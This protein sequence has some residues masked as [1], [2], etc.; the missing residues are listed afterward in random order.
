MHP[1]DHL[2]AAG[3]ALVPL[4][5][6]G[7]SRPAL[8][9]F[10][11]TSVLLNVDHY[12]AYTWKTG[13]LSLWRAYQFH[14]KT[15]PRTHWGVQLGAP[16]LVMDRRRP[17]HALAPIAAVIVAARWWPVLLPAALGAGFHRLQDFLWGC[18]RVPVERSP[19]DE[20]A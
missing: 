12:V 4:A 18:A 16:A 20:N 17:L 6:R 19:A 13:D 1:R 14:Q 10:T 8:A 3:L 7:W 5:R 2:I 9:L 11:A 15:A